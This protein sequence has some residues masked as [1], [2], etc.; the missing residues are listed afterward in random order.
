MP[1]CRAQ[2][3]P[4]S[5]AESNN[6]PLPVFTGC[7]IRQNGSSLWVDRV[8]GFEGYIE[9]YGDQGWLKGFNDSRSIDLA[10]T[11]LKPDEVDDDPDGILV[12]DVFLAFWNENNG[13]SKTTV[14]PF[15]RDERDRQVGHA[16]AQIVLRK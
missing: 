3:Q 15:H 16:I 12:K 4:K 11:K 2:S 8:G 6:V 5:A 13:P 9:R 7:F 14:I 1:G 10:M